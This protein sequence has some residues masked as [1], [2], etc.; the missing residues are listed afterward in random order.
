MNIRTQANELLQA[1]CAHMEVENISL[2]AED[3]AELDIGGRFFVFA[4]SEELEELLSLADIAPLPQTSRRKELL[5][6]LLRG[7]YAWA[8]T[9]GGILGLDEDRVCLSKRYRPEQEE[10]GAFIEKIA[11]QAGLVDHWRKLLTAVPHE[12]ADLP[13]QAVRI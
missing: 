13:A 11:A 9:D 7:T 12:A 6:E 3:R 8:G 2:D 1:L 4:Y 10:A 5:R